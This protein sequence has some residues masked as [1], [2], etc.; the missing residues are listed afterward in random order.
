MLKPKIS[1][2][3]FL[4]FIFFA[5]GVTWYA[6]TR[7]EQRRETILF[8]RYEVGEKISTGALSFTVEKFRHDPQGAG[9]LSPK[10]GYEFLIPTIV[11]SNTSESPFDFSPLLS[12]YVKDSFGNVYPESA[13]PSEGGQLSGPLLPHDILREEVGFEVPLGASGLVLYFESG[14]SGKGTVTVS[15]ENQT[16]W[17]WA[18]DFYLNK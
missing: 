7:G 9:P 17:Q 1:R 10:V 15:L 4:F 11:L 5:M 2:M 6:V 18:K 13:I 8:A 12:L 3:V 16:F 14:R